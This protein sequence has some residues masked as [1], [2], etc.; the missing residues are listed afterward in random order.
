[1]RSEGRRGRRTCRRAGRSSLRNGIISLASNLL[2]WFSDV[3]FGKMVNHKQAL[4]FKLIPQW[5][6]NYIDYGLLSGES[7][8][9]LQYDCG[10][11]VLALFCCGC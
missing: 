2:A 7:S 3:S 4:A 11:A 10:L 8:L 1:L 5:K 6:D 9:R